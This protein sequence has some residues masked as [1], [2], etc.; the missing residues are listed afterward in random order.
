LLHGEHRANSHVPDS[1]L[2]PYA[3]DCC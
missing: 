3:V 1:R 2:L